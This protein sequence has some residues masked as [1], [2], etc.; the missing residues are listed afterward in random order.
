MATK[1]H[2]V[3]QFYLR[4]FSCNEKQLEVYKISDDKL[5]KSAIADCC[6]QRDFYNIRLPLK[7]D[8][9]DGDL[10]R[11]DIVDD[12]IRLNIEEVCAPEIKRFCGLLK[13]IVT[14]VD[15]GFYLHDDMIDIIFNFLIIQYVRTPKF[16][17]FFKP[18][19]DRIFK[20]LPDR[21]HKELSCEDIIKYV[22]ASFMLQIFQNHQM[23]NSYFD[24]SSFFNI[25]QTG[26][27]MFLFNHSKTNVITFDNPVNVVF[28][29]ENPSQI[30]LIYFPL[31]IDT[32]FILFS[33]EDFPSAICYDRKVL[34]IDHS[35]VTVLEN[36]NLLTI[37][38][39][40]EIILGSNVDLKHA[41]SFIN[42]E[43]NMKIS[44]FPPS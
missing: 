22:H 20:L 33:K 34:P 42:H 4:G 30:S 37:D 15:P 35:N 31:N 41:K 19:A 8:S 23:T 38:K 40:H 26:G 9:L 39:A 12:I 3:P 27:R 24:I 36:L 18:L 16:R 7:G 32:A 44:L 5:Y 14:S 10:F 2:Y 1:Q 6:C 25:F 43:I 13:S 17:S 28:S 11:E 21:I 29:T